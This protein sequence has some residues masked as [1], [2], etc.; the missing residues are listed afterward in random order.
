MDIKQPITETKSIASLLSELNNKYTFINL[1]PPYQRG[2]VWKDKES[3]YFIDSI[4][5]NLAPSVITLNLDTKTGKKVC[6]DGKQRLTSIKNFYDNKFCIKI[7]NANYYYDKTDDKCKQ[8]SEKYKSRF[9]NSILFVVTFLDLTYEQQVDLFKRLQ[10]GKIVQNGEKMSCVIASEDNCICFNEYC[11]ILGENMKKFCSCERNEHKTLISRL[12]LFVKNETIE[13]INKSKTDNI[14]KELFDEKDDLNSRS[15][16]N[17]T[18]KAIEK[19]FDVFKS[20]KISKSLNDNIL[21]IAFHKIYQKYNDK[22]SKLD[23]DKYNIIQTIANLHKDKS[24][25]TGIS[26][27]VLLKIANIYDIYL[28]RNIKQITKSKTDD[29]ISCTSEDENDEDE[30]NE[31]D[32]EIVENISSQITN[33]PTKKVNDISEKKPTKKKVIRSIK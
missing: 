33:K 17:K 16:K 32:D 27:K 15:I 21:L 3:V 12:L 31:S 2:F 11:D 7:G 14:I 9:N 6:I 29:D 13:S 8:C 20:D 19:I 28:D 4:M 10:G 25:K 18:F 23:N 22:W 24:I 1:N 26:E 5:N 30:N